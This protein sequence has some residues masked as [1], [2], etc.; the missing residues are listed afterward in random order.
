M[1]NNH[2]KRWNLEEKLEILAS[3][4]REGVVKTSRQFGV[5]NTMIYK[6]QKLI[7]TGGE[8][9]LEGKKEVEKDL[10]FGKLEREN[11]E[12]KSIVAEKELHI[13]ILEEVVKKNRLLPWKQWR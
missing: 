3:Y 6:W 12:L 10:T 5:S 9:S 2:R 13:R 4:K 7:E 8:D 11:R 1:S